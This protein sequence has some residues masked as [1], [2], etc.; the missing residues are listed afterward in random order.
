MNQTE[1]GLYNLEGKAKKSFCSPPL[2]CPTRLLRPP[3]AALRARRSEPATPVPYEVFFD[4]Y[5]LHSGEKERARSSSPPLCRWIGAARGSVRGF[6]SVSSPS[7]SGKDQG[8]LFWFGCFDGSCVVFLGSFYAG[9]SEESNP[10]L[11]CYSPTICCVFLYC[12]DTSIVNSCGGIRIWG[13]T[14]SH[15]LIKC[16]NSVYVRCNVCSSPCLLTFP[17]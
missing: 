12:V 7:S 3:P 5:P 10:D 4:P 16:D 17:D 8:T 15:G 6:G 11:S 1:I 13:S 14:G 9:S 2:R